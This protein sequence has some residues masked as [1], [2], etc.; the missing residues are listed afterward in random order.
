MVWCEFRVECNFVSLDLNPI[1]SMRKIVDDS[2]KDK[3][4]L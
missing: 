3:D 2:V 1:E 4:K